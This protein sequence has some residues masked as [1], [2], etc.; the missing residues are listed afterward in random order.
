MHNKFKETLFCN[1]LNLKY[2]RFLR[3]PLEYFLICCW[4]NYIFGII[5]KKGDNI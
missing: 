4:K 3:N 1:L 5:C 2:F